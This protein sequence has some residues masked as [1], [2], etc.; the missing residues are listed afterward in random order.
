MEKRI[1][2]ENVLASSLPLWGRYKER[3]P[4]LEKVTGE[5]LWGA[6][7]MDLHNIIVLCPFHKLGS[8]AQEAREH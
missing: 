5:L 7:F 8:G 4:V 3:H 2:S 6:G 1:I